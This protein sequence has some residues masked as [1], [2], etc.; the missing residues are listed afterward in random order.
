[1]KGI[2]ALDLDGTLL[3]KNQ[4]V[5]FN[6][7][8]AIKYAI[9]KGYV[10]MVS[11]GRALANVNISLLEELGIDYVIHL[12]GARVTDIRSNTAIYENSMD[13]NLAFALFD[14]FPKTD[15]YKAFYLDERAVVPSEDLEVIYRL[16]FPD[17]NIQTFNRSVDYV[18]HPKEHVR[19]LK[20]GIY[21]ISI[22]FVRSEL[23]E[24][25]KKQVEKLFGLYPQLK[26]VSGGFNCIEFTDKEVSKGQALKRLAES[27]DVDIKNCIA[28]GDSENDLDMIVTAGIGVAMGNGETIVKEN[29]DYITD[30]CYNDGVAKA[31]YK[32]I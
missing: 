21:K 29:A 17:S 23:F 12:N 2:I 25:N 6:N 19:T 15:T 26:G 4:S 13:Q 1:M 16:G 18:E 7:R 5:S 3:G 8:E 11:T 32:F 10:V 27:F 28:I 14:A 31:I 9:A 24:K 30:D 22:D 20:Q